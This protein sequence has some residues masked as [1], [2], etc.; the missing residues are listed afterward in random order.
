M[1]SIIKSN[2]NEKETKEASWIVVIDDYSG[3]NV[4]E[5]SDAIGIDLEVEQVEQRIGNFNAD[6]IARDTF[7][8]SKIV[9][10]W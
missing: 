10:A 4:E 5:L 2:E 1:D 8:G 3:K 9:K 6:I 7:V